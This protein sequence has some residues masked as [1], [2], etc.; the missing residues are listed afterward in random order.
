[1]SDRVRVIG[2]TGGI[3]SGKSAVGALLRARGAAIVDADLL[4]RAVVAPGQPALAELVARFGK[5]ILDERGELD[6]KKVGARVF[7]DALARAELNRITH[8]RI[9]AASQAEIAR[10]AAGGAKVVFY[11]AALLIENRA[12][13]WLDGVIVVS[14]PRE[15]Q[16]ARLMARD[17]L[18]AVAADAR[19]EA[20]LPLEQKL[21]VATWVIDN[22]GTPEATVAQV[23]A[24]WH[25]LESKYG[26]IAPPPERP[27]L[28]MRPTTRPELRDARERDSRDS[29][30]MTAVDDRDA[31]PLAPERVLITGFPAFTA[32]RMIKK[33][34]AADPTAELRILARAKFTDEAREFVASLPVGQRERAS[35]VIGDVCDMDLGLSS[36]EY[37]ALTADL[38]SIHHLAGIYWTGIDAQTARRVNV[39]GTRGVLELAGECT[40][41]RR[42]MHWSTT[43]VSGKRRGVVLEDEL[44]G[45]TGFHNAYEA[46]KFDAERLARAAAHK[47]PITV[48]RP[49][50]IVG[51]SVTGEIDRFDGP[52]Y[53]IVMIATNALGVHLPLPGRGT[54]PLHLVPIDYVVDAAYALWRDERAA[55]RTFHLVDP[56]PLPARRV[57]E[58]VA[59]HSQTKAP[60]GYIPGRLARAVLRAPGLSRLAKGPQSYLDAFDQQV[61]YNQQGTQDLLAST[62]ITCPPVESYLHQLATY[63][64][65][66]H[67]TKKRDLEDETFDPFL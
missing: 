61:F 57:F 60:R 19:L 43:Q 52:Y 16:R 56:N 37:R 20:Q 26:P 33:I 2:L 58:L 8:P 17:G 66:V 5:D 13:T 40:R 63:V 41:L 14:A 21:A 25:E 9:A 51:D 10:H 50:L 30:S 18:D 29:A 36:A 23:D 64:R 12:Q 24:L 22:S 47:L 39:G 32:R 35:V 4:A 42:L 15:V 28:R 54:A 45:R 55:G 34:A 6:R 53:L 31:G 27:P 65:Q 44:D 48:L 62:G 38:T 7:G 67:G 1:M 59:E 46:T 49:G 11:E 3:A